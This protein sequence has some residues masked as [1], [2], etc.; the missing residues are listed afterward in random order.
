MMAR[1]AAGVL[2]AVLAGLAT[3]TFAQQPEGASPE[4]RFAIKRFQVEGNTLLKAADIARIVARYTGEKKDFSDVQRALEALEIAYRNLGYG[5]V[6]VI[7][8][9]QNIAS[10]VV[11]F[12][13]VEPRLTRI[14]IDGA[15]RNDQANIRRSVP[16]LR[17]GE[18]PNSKTIARNLLLANENPARQLTVLMR[19][20]ESEE[21]VDATIKVVED[22]PW[23]AS[24]A[25]DNTG[26]TATGE[27]RVNAGYQYANVFNRDHVLT[28]QYITSPNH[29]ADVKVYGFGYRIPLYNLGSS[30]EFIGGYSNVSSGSLGGLFSVSGSGTIGGLRFNH[31]LSKI[32]DYEQKLVYGLDYKAFQ[33]SVVSNGTNVVPDITVH[34]ISATYYG[35]LRGEASEAGFYVSV[36]QNVFPGGSDGT[37]ANFKASRADAKAAYRIYRFGANYSRALANDWQARFQTT[38]QYTD[39]A[40]VAGEQ[41][42]IGGAENL[43]GFLEREVANDL[44]YRANAE[45]FT[46]NIGAKLGWYSTQARLLGFVDW[47]KVVRNNALPGESH[48]QSLASVGLGLRVNAGPRFSLRTDYARVIDAGGVETKGHTRVHFSLSLVF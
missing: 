35:T 7:L 36:S 1:A 33:N 25:L 22:K 6:Q 32:G 39:D 42:G 48:Q 45:V 9:E 2:F 21:K 34:P 44:G 14:E 11:N 46:P 28:F 43:R 20:G 3:H 30:V 27:L 41:F 18:I 4:L 17:E 38:G 12:N 37:D 31:Y 24:I 10:G 26:N 13:V 8:P 16:G 19:S 23:K 40:L 47:G 29:L 15:E 5:A